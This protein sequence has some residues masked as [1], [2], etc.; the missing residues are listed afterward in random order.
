[1]RRSL[2]RVKPPELARVTHLLAA[3]AVEE[4]LP[5][6]ADLANADIREKSPGEI[7]TAADD[8]M[9]RRLAPVLA[10]L[11]PGSVV[12]GEE[13]T[14]VDGSLLALLE[15]G[16]PVWL[17]D[18]L[19]GTANFAA[20]VP[21]FGVMVCLVSRAELAAAWIHHPVSGQTLVA[22]AG[23]GAWLD[24]T[25]LRIS[26]PAHRPLTASISTK[27]F[28]TELRAAGEAARAIFEHREPWQCAARTYLDLA[29]GGLD[30]AMFYRLMPWDHAPGVLI[31][32]EAGG[33]ST[34]FK[35]APYSP[36]VHT[37]GLFLGPDEDSW[38]ELAQSF[39]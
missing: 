11:L 4:I 3:A 21:V 26:P 34:G 37:G 6:F 14:A 38:R 31:H 9:E 33:Y 32:R 10:E 15:G 20:G 13:A 27:F 35:G 12:V 22:E 8:A 18:P 24:G 7:V 39:R 16:S 2:I 36:L 25:Q 29:T 17:I 28:P 30:V 1:M 23:S 5:R 19:D